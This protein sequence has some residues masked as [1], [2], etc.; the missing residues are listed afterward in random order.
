[1]IREKSS[2]EC[3]STDLL[4]VVDALCWLC[5]CFSG[6][7]IVHPALHRVRAHVEHWRPAAVLPA[8]E[9]GKLS[10]RVQAAAVRP[11]LQEQRPQRGG[12]CVC[13]HRTVLLRDQP[14]KMA[15]QG[16]QVVHQL[17]WWAAHRARVGRGNHTWTLGRWLLV[18][19]DKFDSCSPKR[20]GPQ[21]FC[22]PGP[23]ASWTSLFYSQPPSN[24]L[25]RQPP[26][27]AI[28]VR[29]ETEGLR[30]AGAMVPEL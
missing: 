7:S 18:S 23:C 20:T 24:E 21:V 5:V 3:A 16:N 13:V 12:R 8:S 19:R 26:G 22:S 25:L 27:A 29:I 1:M 2:S 10:Y 4:V 14:R 30:F 9:P 11:G 15:I 28:F 17:L 6:H